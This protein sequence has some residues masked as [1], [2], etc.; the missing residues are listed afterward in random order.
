MTGTAP[1]LPPVRRF[2]PHCIILD[3]GFQHLRLKRDL[4][5]LLFDS[6]RGIRERTPPPEGDIEG[7][8]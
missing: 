2:D 8:P 1:V 6:S 4:N 7:A 3:D 5:I